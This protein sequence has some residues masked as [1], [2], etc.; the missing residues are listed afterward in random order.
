M[1]SLFCPAFC[2]SEVTN[3]VPFDA[4]VSIFAVFTCL[5]RLSVCLI[6]T[7]YSE[8]AVFW[9]AP[10]RYK[11]QLDDKGNLNSA[12]FW[13]RSMPKLLEPWFV[14]PIPP[15]PPQSF[16]S[17]HSAHSRTTPDSLSPQWYY[18]FVF[19]F[20]LQPNCYAKIVTVENNKKIVIYSKR[21][22]QINEE[23]TY[24]YKFPI[25]EEKIPCLCGAPQCRGTLNWFSQHIRCED[26][27]T[28]STMHSHIIQTYFSNKPCF[29]DVCISLCS[30]IPAART[31]AYLNQI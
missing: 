16:H 7:C 3:R 15:T 5:S 4:L 1:P 22:I 18:W 11:I 20:N 25:E 17:R 31:K 26:S 9:L 21:D 13:V 19:S 14:N 28:L 10:S 6:L 30:D 2:S 29:E 23:I 24:D 27:H 8:T 12:N